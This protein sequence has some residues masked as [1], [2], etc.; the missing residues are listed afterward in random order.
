MGWQ[1]RDS[2]AIV[3]EEA[4]DLHWLAHI[5]VMMGWINR[6]HRNPTYSTLELGTIH[7]DCCL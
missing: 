3:Q 2:M 7:S 4:S 5:I 6:E 1:L